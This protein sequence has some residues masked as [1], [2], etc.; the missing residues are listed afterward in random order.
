MSEYT[1]TEWKR[2]DLITSNKLNNI[3]NGV[4]SAHTEVEEV[5]GLVASHAD[6]IAANA[7]KAQ[8]AADLVLEKTGAIEADLEAR[9]QAAAAHIEAYQDTVEK[10]AQNISGVAEAKAAANLAQQKADANETSIGGIN[11]Q[12]TNLT[13]ED[14]V[15]AQMIDAGVAPMISDDEYNT[16]QQARAAAYDLKYGTKADVQ[17]A[18]SDAA[19]AVENVELA[20][21]KIDEL[22]ATVNAAKDELDAA[23]ALIQGNAT[24]IQQNADACDAATTQINQNV[25]KIN[26]LIS[27]AEAHMAQYSEVV[28]KLDQNVNVIAAATNTANEAKATADEAKTD[29]S[30]ASSRASAAELAAGTARS[31]ADSAAAS[32]TSAQNS[33]TEAA[34]S[35]NDAAASAALAESQATIANTRAGDAEG[36]AET[37]SAQATA[38]AGSAATAAAEATTAK[39][40]A[41]AANTTA[42]DAQVKAE[43]ALEKLADAEMITLLRKLIPAGL[44]KFMDPS[45]PTKT[46]NP[47]SIQHKES[48]ANG[49]YSLIFGESDGGG[50]MYNSVSKKIKGSVCVNDGS[51]DILCQIYARNED[52][53][54]EDYKKGARLAAY[55]DGMY[56]TNGKKDGSFDKSKHEIMNREMVESAISSAMGDTRELALAGDN[57]EP[58]ASDVALRARMKALE[59]QLNAVARPDSVSTDLAGLDGENAPEGVT[60]SVVDNKK[61]ISAPD[62]DLVFNSSAPVENVNNITAKSIDVK[63]MVAAN[64]RLNL[65]ADGPITLSG[66]ETSGTLAKTVSNA[67]FSINTSDHIRITDSEIAATCYNQIEI[68]LT[69]GSQA[70]SVIIDGVNFSG[71]ISNNAISVFDTA[72]YCQITIANC[73]FAETSNPLRISNRS[74]VHVDVRFLNCTFG[75]TDSN[76]DYTGLVLCQ[77]YTDADAAAAIA[78]NRFAPEKVSISFQNCTYKGINMSAF[79]SKAASEVCGSRNAS[80]LIYVYRDKGGLVAYNATV[81]PKLTIDGQILA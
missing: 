43:S 39:E 73:D 69:A 68:G 79:K 26:K 19:S 64:A 4:E 9:A 31:D 30:D 49:D 38:A 80:Q 75:I 37:A 36:A 48:L 25:V 11:D 60:V 67:A 53:T 78:A 29:A 21:A 59:D 2:G 23:K 17:T 70:R 10:V 58:L 74:N 12:L 51:G 41:Q 47:K 66:M 6:Q 13:K 45:D 61:T 8:E 71:K 54:S 32:A 63:S 15:I 72:D 34:S 7:Q 5:R 42:A 24:K 77:S 40:Q 62:V 50:I 18:L 35:A 28:A 56:Y 55:V 46:I 20:Q 14:G 22:E 52:T 44:I 16:D 57:A 27:D 76:L 1:K 33:A 3:E 65:A 81:Y